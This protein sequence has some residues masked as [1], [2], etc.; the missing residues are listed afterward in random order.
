MLYNKNSHKLN[1]HESVTTFEL[2]TAENAFL[3]RFQWK[4]GNTRMKS[5][6][7]WGSI[8]CIESALFEIKS[9]VCFLSCGYF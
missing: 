2:Q 1:L 3:Y 8:T 6:G 4:S 7:N 5:C 9:P